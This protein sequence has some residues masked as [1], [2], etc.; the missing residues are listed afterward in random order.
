MSVTIG[1]DT[2]R[3]STEAGGLQK[4][5]HLFFNENWKSKPILMS[6]A[7][8]LKM[9]LV[10]GLAAEMGWLV[11]KIRWL[12]AEMRWLVRIWAAWWCSC[13]PSPINYKKNISKQ[14][15]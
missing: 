12:V 10:F 3:H 6:P 2:N 7:F 8:L 14:V 15:C 1:E 13:H 5:L 4:L 9:G 11:A